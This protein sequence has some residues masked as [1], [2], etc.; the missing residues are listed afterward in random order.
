MP[1]NEDYTCRDAERDIRMFYRGTALTFDK[2][3][4]LIRA[5]NHATAGSLQGEHHIACQRCWDFHMKM[6]QRHAG[7]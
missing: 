4:A 6:K 3:T 2:E 1:A 7:G 5:L